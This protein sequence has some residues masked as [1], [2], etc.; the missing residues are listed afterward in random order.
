MKALIKSFPR[1]L[2]AAI[3]MGK[4]AKFTPVKKEIR[5]VLVSGLGGSGTGGTFVQQWV[6]KKI[7]LPMAVNHDYFLPA[8]V[9]EHTLLIIVSYS[10][11]TEETI[12]ALQE[13]F[14]KKAKIVCI[15]S[16]GKVKVIAEKEGLDCIILPGGMPPRACLGYT[17]IQ[18]LFV[19]RAYQCISWNFTKALES[20]VKLLD[21]TQ[22]TVQEEAQQIAEKLKDKLPVIY[23]NTAYEAVAIR[24]RQ[25]INENSKKLCWH[26]VFPEMNHNEL[27]GWRTPNEQLA[28]IM[29]KDEHDYYRIQARMKLTKEV[30]QQYTSTILEINTKGRTYL[31]KTIYLIHLCDWVSYYLAQ[32]NG[33]DPTEVA[34]IDHLKVSLAQLDDGKMSSER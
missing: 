11:N 31:E 15:T 21:K 32:L 5:N 30:F 12:H 17:T 23:S 14:Q 4:Q 24:F 34:V 25:Q 26:H 33:F 6:A 18:Q 8:Y 22:S 20:V 1:Q 9:N 13:G 27:V 28:V 7:P 16:G 19:L 2:E 3:T 29:L 10:G